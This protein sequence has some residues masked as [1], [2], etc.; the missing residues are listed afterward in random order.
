VNAALAVARAVAAGP[1]RS[2]LACGVGGAYPGSG[3]RVGDVVCASTETYA[4]LGADG[5]DGFAGAEALGFPV[6]AGRA[7]PLPLDLFPCERRAPFATRS[8]C[9]GR[10]GDARAIAARTGAAVESMEG[11]AF[12]HAALVF[13][14]RVGEIRGVSNLAGD[15]DRAAWR[16]REAAEAAQEALLRWLEDGAC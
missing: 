7:G 13:G 2:V 11:A 6:V 8:T 4:D 1:V 16:V 15:R 5:P 3:L 10:D 9:T 12:V 14:L